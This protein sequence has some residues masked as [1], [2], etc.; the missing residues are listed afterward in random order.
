MSLSLGGKA[1]EICTLAL[2]A[3]VVP[4][5]LGPSDYGRFAVP[6]TVVTLGSLAMTLGGPTLMARYV[7]AAAAHDRIALAKTIGARLARGRALQTAA[8]AGIAAL[9]V[10]ADVLPPLTT[11]IVVV[12]LALNVAATL[13][14]QVTLGLGRTGAWS[15][16]YP[17]Q[18]A[19]L[20]AAVLVL[21]ATSGSRGAVFAIAVAAIAGAGFAALVV[22]P[23]VR[24]ATPRVAV[25]DGAIRFGI[26]QATGAALT[27]FSQ[28]G[29][30]LAV[31][32]LATSS[33]ETGYVALATGIALG[34]TYAVLQTFTV[35]LTHLAD[36][37]DV[38]EAEVALR[39]LAGAL[40]AVIIPA[41]VVGA[42]VLEHVVPVVFGDDYTGAVDAFGPAL[43]LVVLAPSYSLGVQ[44]AALRMR[45]QV[46]TVSGVASALT[47]VAVALV[48][49]PAWDAA[50]ATAAS[51]AGG[52]VGA[53]AAVRML[54]GAFGR[55]IVGTT[56]V[57]VAAVL[58]AAVVA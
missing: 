8:I 49:V 40:L 36:G 27:Q 35:S 5:V 13:A 42:L 52:A 3:T 53:L 57:G 51:L 10:A 7:P 26:H 11:G 38:D 21:H 58:A 9:L 44:V 28:R 24:P 46:A 45:P 33:T 48:A 16:R 56:F 4:R 37:D 41:A 50:G 2:L 15:F 54:P 55:H 43:A 20:I 30:V 19:A 14:L 34:V 18:N 12:A 47:F 22:V 31:A 39:R 29:S 6:L 17:I 25:P 23:V 1:V 32:V